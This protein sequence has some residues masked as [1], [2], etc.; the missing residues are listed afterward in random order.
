MKKLFTLAGSIKFVSGCCAVF[1]TG[2][3]I[4]TTPDLYMFGSHY[5]AGIVTAV[6]TFLILER[7]EFDDEEDK[8][9]GH[10]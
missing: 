2:F 7:G 1:A 4:L 8:P 3:S 9:C 5:C 10:S 6:A